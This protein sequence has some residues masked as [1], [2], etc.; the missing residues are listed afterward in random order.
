MTVFLGLA[1]IPLSEAYD[2]IGAPT[3]RRIEEPVKEEPVVEE[4]IPEEPSVEEE[5]AVQEEVPTVQEEEPVVEEVVPQEP[6]KEPVK[7]Q[8]EPV[9]ETSVLPEPEIP[10]PEVKSNY[11]EIDYSVLSKGTAMDN[12]PKSDS[13]NYV[14]L[15]RLENCPYC[16]KMIS[17]FKDNIGDYHLVVV[18]CPGTVNDVFYRRSITY[19]PSFIVITDKVVR[20]YGYGYRTLEEFKRLL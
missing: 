4:S 12:L 7:E 19:F 8:P 6:V 2:F 1:N 15:Y 13:G 17:A 3:L 18:K 10:V 14:I 9:E 11:T 5:T 16:D 20:Y